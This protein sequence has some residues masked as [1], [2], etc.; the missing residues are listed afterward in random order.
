[1]GEKKTFSVEIGGKNLIFE[2]GKLAQQADGAVLAK[3]GEIAI[4][5][6]AQMSAPR[7][8]DFFPMLVDFEAKFYASGKMKG[9]RFS[10]REARPPDSAILSAR[11]IDRTLRPLFPKNTRSDIQIIATM[12]QSDETFSPNATAINAASM[13]VQLSGFPVE[14]PVGAVRVGLREN[15]EFFLDPTFDEIKNGKLDLII[16]GTEDA[17]LMVE[18]GANLISDEKMIAAFEF[19][20]AE[21]K[22]ICAAQKKFL[23][24]FSIEKKELILAEEN[25]DAKNAVEKIFSE[26]DFDEIS[27]DKKKVKKK[28]SEMQKKLFE[29]F[30]NEIAAEKFSE[31]NLQKYFEKNFAASLRRRVFEKKIR[32]DERAPDEIRALSCEV[33]ILPRLH[34]SAIFQR[35]ETQAFS[36]VTVGGPGDEKI[37]DDPEQP[38]F[39]KRYLH[40]YNFPPFSVGETRPMRG[41]GRRE[42]GHGELAHRAL[43][44]VIPEKNENF[45]YVLRVVSEILACNG[46]SSMASVCGSTLSLMDAGI[47]I[48]T[49]IA[50]I[51]MGLLFENSEKY[52]ILTDIQGFEDFDGDMDFKVAGDENGITALQLDMKIKGLK[53]EI[54]KNAF[55][56]AKIARQKILTEM[57]KTISAPR[58]KMSDFA[59]RVFS[60]KI[61]PDFIRE[62]IGKGGENIQKICA[63]NSVEI[64]IEDSG[65]VFITAKNGDDAENTKKIILGIAHEPEPGEIFENCEV[66]KITDFGAFVEFL[67]KKEALVH[68]SEMADHRVE[69]VSDILKLGQKITVQFLGADKMGRQRL[70]MK[71]KK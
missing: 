29:N 3:Y 12:L 19:A 63:E 70:T 49:P 18:A 50:G 4:L 32:L 48:K 42:I 58:E 40:H 31:K 41:P 23:E 52:E 28:I 44:Y 36:V 68:I 33:G 8:A 10:K 45:P 21:I 11:L 14:S 43:R 37:V 22:K 66:K 34:G 20:H 9:S 26:K 62:I 30:A 1:M 71:I 55:A 13:A 39:K 60:I 46:S 6:T 5:A 54:L 17:I 27:G 38:E 24:N 59:P 53:I 64:D 69:K 65:L 47:K 67:P 61:N 35:G 51:A 7:G 15:D 56:K 2:T 57:K 25:L 16:A